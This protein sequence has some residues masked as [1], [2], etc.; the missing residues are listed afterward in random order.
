VGR[1]ITGQNEA[2]E[3]LRESEQRFRDLADKAPV[4]IYI[5]EGTTAVYVNQCF[6]EMHGY[7]PE[8]LIGKDKHR[9]LT[10]PDDWDKAEQRVL[11]RLSAGPGY[12]EKLSFRGITK[13]GKTIYVE[14]HSTVTTYQG[15]PAVIGIGNDVTDQKRIEEE[16][17]K[18]RN[19]LEKLVAEKTAELNQTNE[20]LRQDILRRK[21]VESE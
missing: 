8:E 10:H 17:E 7:T 20:E 1:I 15:R 4:G 9:E 19:H 6:A 16:L 5:L 2:E 13:T 18:H 21:Q 11:R 12:K 14:G 3:A